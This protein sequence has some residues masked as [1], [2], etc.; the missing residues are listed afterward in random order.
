MHVLQKLFLQQVTSCGSR[1]SLKQT[2]HPVSI[3]PEVLSK[4]SQGYPPLGRVACCSVCDVL[5]GVAIHVICTGTELIQRKLGAF[6]YTGRTGGRSSVGKGPGAVPIDLYRWVWL[7]DWQ[8]VATHHR[9]KTGARGVGQAHV[10][11]DI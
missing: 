10:H 3:D 1:R 7:Q 6:F 9:T 5:L 4:T 2:G 11:S 8:K